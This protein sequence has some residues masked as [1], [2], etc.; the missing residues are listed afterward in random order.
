MLVTGIRDTAHIECPNCVSL[1]E[2]FDGYDV[3]QDDGSGLVTNFR[4]I[5]RVE[6]DGELFTVKAR[7]PNDEVAEELAALDGVERQPRT[8]LIRDV[9]RLEVD[10]D[11]SF[12]V[13]VRGGTSHHVD[14]FE[15]VEAYEDSARFA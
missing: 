13:V 12:A 2:R 4:R 15:L 7:V 3:S 14:P 1:C 10:T 9:E 6:E 8:V 5:D 11:A